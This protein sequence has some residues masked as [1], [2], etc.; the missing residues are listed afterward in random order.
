VG[1]EMLAEPD[2]WKS[3]S[4][5]DTLKSAG[6]AGASEEVEMKLSKMNLQQKFQRQVTLWPLF[7]VLFSAFIV[8]MMSRFIFL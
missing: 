7:I 8:M 4:R 1:G 2:A 3:M 5:K 6:S